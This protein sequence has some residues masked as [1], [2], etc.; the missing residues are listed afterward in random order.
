M[1]GLPVTIRLLDPP[2]HEFL[3]NLP[4]LRAHVE[5]ARIEVTDDLDEL[6][7]L[8]TRVEESTRAIQCSA[9]GGPARHPVPRDLRDAGPRDHA[10][11]ARRSTSR[12]IPRS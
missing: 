5:R 11:R 2:L 9:R 4:E 12:L 8:L 1:K 10:R 7:T 6:E 3:P